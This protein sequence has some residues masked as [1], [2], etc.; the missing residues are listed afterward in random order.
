MV[1]FTLEEA[2]NKVKMPQYPQDTLKACYNQP[3]RIYH[4]LDHIQEM[5][6]WLPRDLVEVEIAIDAILFH[7]LVHA[8]TPQA[9]GLNETLSTAE[10][11]F[12]NT[13]LLAFDTPFGNKGEGSIEYEKRVLEAIN[14]TAHHLVDQKNISYTTQMILDLDL[15][16]FALPRE[17][18]LLWKDKIIKENDIIYGENAHKGRMLFLNALQKRENIYYTHPQWEQPARVNIELDLI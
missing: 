16:T 7:D 8:D 4:N 12:Y 6:R 15:C 17:E 11:L 3:H 18:Y 5:L 1:G 14:A 9:L 13:K 10:Y 2:F